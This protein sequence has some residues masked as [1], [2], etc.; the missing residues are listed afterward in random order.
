[1]SSASAASGDHIY[2]NGSSGSDAN[3]GL[4]PQTAKL[5]IKNATGTVN[6]GGTVSI[7]S[8]TY[9]GAG[10]TNIEISHDMTI[11]G[12]GKT[13]TII[14]GSDSS[15]IFV[16]DNNVNFILKN[17]TIANGKSNYGGGILNYGHT[18]VDNAV[19]SQCK[20]YYAYL[21]GGSAIASTEDGTL[22]VSNTDFLNNDASLSSTAGGTIYTNGTL[23]IN[24]CNFL[25]NIAY[26]GGCVFSYAG[27][28]NMDNSNFINNT[29]RNGGGVLTLYGANNNA[30]IHFCSFVGNK[31]NTVTTTN[32]IDN[33]LQN[34]MNVNSCWWGSNAGPNGIAGP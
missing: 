15:R 18:T 11:I 21:G 8:G 29:A 30:Q 34:S 17:L 31:A 20:T 7:S 10:N 27:T 24:N 28:V 25:S 4:T 6:I 19:F 5:T 23:T 26:S 33:R 2:V 16:I 22:L 3:D 32:N 1:M 13:K 12:A 9:N 14:S